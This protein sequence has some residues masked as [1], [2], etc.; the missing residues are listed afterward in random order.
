MQELRR[1]LAKHAPRALALD[2][3]ARLLPRNLAHWAA[4]GEWEP[5]QQAFYAAHLEPVT[6]G[7]DLP[8]DAFEVL[9]DEGAGMVR[10]FI[11][12][13][14]F[15]ARFGE[16][17]ELNVVVDYLARR[18]WRE[19]VPAGATSK[20]FAIPPCR[21]TRYRHRP[22]TAHDGARPPPRWRAGSGRGKAR[23]ARRSTLGPSGRAHRS[24]P[25]EVPVHG[26]HL[27]FRH[28][29][30]REL[31][32]ALEKMAGELQHD[33]RRDS[34]KRG[35]TAPVT[36]ELAREVMVRTP[37]FARIL[38]QF[39]LFDAVVR[40]RAP[41]PELRNTDDE[42]MLLCEVRFPLTGAAA[43]VAEALDGIDGFEREEDGEPRWRWVAAGSPLYRASRH[44]PGQ[45]AT[46]SSETPIGTTSLGYIETRKGTLL[47][48]VNSRERAERG[49]ELLA[50][51]LGDLVGPALIAHQTPERALEERSGQAPDEP[52]VPPEEALQ[53]MHSYL[54]DHYRR[55]LDEPFPM[56]D[57]K[58]LREAAATSKGRGRV[59]DW[60]KQ[61]ENAEHHRAAQHGHRPYDTAW[62]WR[63]LGIEAPR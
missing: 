10:V 19:S 52:E 26:R 63:E 39:W 12:E 62:L 45:S 27:R 28:E 29:V 1:A 48:S 61:L 3:V 54:D 24:R 4:R 22:R 49:R 42:A 23:L 16:H 34:R 21:S 17:D 40:A 33:I 25:R 38:S 6:D 8:D 31:L 15:T 44:W 60:L 35:A 11:V 7:L 59:V 5:L 20:R 9:P 18:G 37:L 56:L 58:T 50:S 47:L 14:F 13:E 46:E 41:A 53:V 43:R 30:S 32:T 36:R 57:G 51:H 2:A 55:I